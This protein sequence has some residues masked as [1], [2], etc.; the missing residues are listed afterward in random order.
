MKVGDLVRCFPKKTRTLLGVIV[1][2]RHYPR[3]TTY[4]VLLEGHV[5]PFDADK[6]EAINE[7]R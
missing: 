6:L 7:S 4:N 2:V 1:S 5:S 3:G